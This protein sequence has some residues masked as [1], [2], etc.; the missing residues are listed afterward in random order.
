MSDYAVQ[1]IFKGSCPECG[2]YQLHEESRCVMSGCCTL[3]YYDE[4][5]CKCGEILVEKSGSGNFY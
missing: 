4:I 3:H 2:V 1:T 5:K